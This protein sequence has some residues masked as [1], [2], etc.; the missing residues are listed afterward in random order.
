[1][2]GWEL[3]SQWV[4]DLPEPAEERSDAAGQFVGKR[5]GSARAVGAGRSEATPAHTAKA[6]PQSSPHR[7]HNPTKT[8]R[9]AR[10]QPVWF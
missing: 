10:R 8:I 6:L 2:K 7:E 5:A 1:M 4:N 3:Y 9:A